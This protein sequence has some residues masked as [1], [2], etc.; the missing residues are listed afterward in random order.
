MRSLSCGILVFEPGGDLLLCHL[1]GTPWWDIP[2]GLRDGTETEQQAALR[3][4]EEE[5]GLQLQAGAL[6]ELG[7]YRYR[8]AKDLHLFATL[9]ARTDIA[10]LHCRSVFTDR[11]GRQRPE[12]DAFA[13]VPLAE[14]PL[15]CAPSLAEVLTRQVDLP[16][17]LQRLKNRQPG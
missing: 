7:R 1:T 2:K 12:A 15:H 3:E 4:A 6:I 10:Q 11:W 9:H 17:L 13:W 8:P 14:L 16:A 5:C